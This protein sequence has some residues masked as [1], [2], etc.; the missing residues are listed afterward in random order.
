M[1]LLLFISFHILAGIGFIFFKGKLPEKAKVFT[2]V[3]L[4]MSF[5]YW[6]NVILHI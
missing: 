6:G 2:F 1:S 4:T 3:F 5:L